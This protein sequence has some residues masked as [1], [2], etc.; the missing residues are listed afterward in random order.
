MVLNQAI[1]AGDNVAIPR[2]GSGEYIVEL[3][4]QLHEAGY[5]VHLSLVELDLIKAA[6]H[7]VTRYFRRGRFVDP[8]YILGEVGDKPTEFFEQLKSHPAVATFKR[9]D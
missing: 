5:T 9:V 3:V 6:G 1:K 7:A 2:V 4:D 8:T